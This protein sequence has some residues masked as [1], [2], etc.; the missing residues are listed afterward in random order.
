MS[1]ICRFTVLASRDLESILDYLAEQSSIDAA[2]SFLEKV[3]QKCQN[4]VNFPSLGRSRDELFPGIRSLPIDQYLIFYRLQEEEIEIVR[5][6]SGYQ[7]LDALFKE[8]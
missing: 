8:S 3:N 7:D 6:V 4:L 5:I 1:R 2:E